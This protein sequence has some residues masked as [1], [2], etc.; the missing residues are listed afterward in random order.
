[1]TKVL[2]IGPQGSGKSTQAALLA[3]FLKVPKITMGDIFRVTAQSDA[4]QGQRIKE[5]LDKGNLVD[6]LT[7]SG[8]IK[9][10]LNQ[11]DCQTGFV[12]DGYP[13]TLEQVKLFEPDF[14]K[15]FYLEVPNE[16]ILKRLLDRGRVDDTPELIKRR[17]DL[18][19][20]QT[21][22]LL[23]YYQNKGILVE[24]DGR[25]DINMIQEAIRGNFNSL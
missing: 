15:V 9:D 3:G 17:L 5:I 12:L 21:Q 14:D 19:F 13:R 16:E 1:M 24:V 4:P 11:V 2:L 7:T 10:R 18:Y 23:D 20:N 6:D 8:M 22:P 25:G